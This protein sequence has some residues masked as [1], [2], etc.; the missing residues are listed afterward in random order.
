M[1]VTWFRHDDAGYYRWLRD[2][3][4]GYVVATWIPITSDVP[5]LHHA[6]CS[7]INRDIRPRSWTNSVGKACSDDKDAAVLWVAHQALQPVR[8]CEHCRP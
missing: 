3:P 2:H 4:D 5:V 1:D 8:S 6:A 7:H